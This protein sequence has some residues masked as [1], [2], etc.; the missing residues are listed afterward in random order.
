MALKKN[1]IKHLS[2]GEPTSHTRNTQN[3]HGPLSFDPG[4]ILSAG[5]AHWLQSSWA[6]SGCVKTK[7]AQHPLWYVS[8]QQ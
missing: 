5:K 2:V 8:L 1:K 4:E 7:L 6:A 3:S